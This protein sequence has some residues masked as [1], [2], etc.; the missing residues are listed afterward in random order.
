MSRYRLSAD[1]CSARWGHRGEHP[2][3]TRA[4]HAQA[5]LEHDRHETVLPIDSDYWQWVS[6]VTANTFSDPSRGP[7]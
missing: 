4:K 1:E 7:A 6:D 3:H 5:R 2:T